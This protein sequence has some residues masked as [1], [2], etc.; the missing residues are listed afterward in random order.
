MLPITVAVITGG[1]PFD[2]Q[3]FHQLFRS[4]PG[5]DAYI[6]HTDEFASE[7]AEVRDRY[8]ALVFYSMFRDTPQDNVLWYTGKPKTA[9]EHI[10]ETKQGIVLIHHAVLAYRDWSVW[11]ELV[12]MKRRQMRSYHPNEQV[13]VEIADP[14]HPIVM[15]MASWEMVDETYILEDA[16]LPDADPSNHIFL[17]T[18]NPRS[19]QPLGWTRT[20]KQARVFNFVSGHGFATYGDPNFRAVL[21]NGIR[22]A[23]ND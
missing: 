2:V 9:L 11:D 20:Y 21:V 19:I 22:W 1:H 6:Q 3:P 16:I 15:G 5:I 8:D 14:S 10:G 13:K 17:T 7:P 4:L 23:A 12:G 18:Q